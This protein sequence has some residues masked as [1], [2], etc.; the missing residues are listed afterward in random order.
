[1]RKEYGNNGYVI[2][3]NFLSDK[4]RL[5]LHKVL[6]YFHQRWQEKNAQF[7]AD[8]AINSA[9]LTG[10]DCLNKSQRKVLFDFIGSTK[11]MEIVTTVIPEQPC[12]MNTQLFFDPVNAA[13]KN[14][15][16]RDP[17]YHLSVEQQQAALSASDVIHF[18]LPLV[19]EPGIE[20]I[21]GTHRRWDSSEELAVRL[22]QN[23]QKNHQPLACG[24][25]IKL[26]AGDLLVF[27]ANMIHRGLYGMNR[28]ALDILFCQPEPSVIQF[29]NDDCLPTADIL[30]SVENGKSFRNTIAAKAEIRT[31]TNNTIKT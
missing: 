16:H 10:T 18:R 29:V 19:D 31:S 2:I 30:S 11:L 21:P 26:A 4:E 22:E 15:W 14:Y 9:Y 25:T 5:D 23:N 6:S 7:Y 13:Q 28:L 3:K 12:F 17:Q 24:K 8:G 27:S 20:V 1:M